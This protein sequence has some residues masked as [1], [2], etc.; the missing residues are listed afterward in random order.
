MIRI[1]SYPSK[2]L[3][4]IE[5]KA[6]RVCDEINNNNRNQENRTWLC[7]G[8]PGGKIIV[9]EKIWWRKSYCGEKI[10]WRN[11]CAGGKI[12]WWKNILVKIPGDKWPSEK[13]CPGRN[14]S[15][16]ANLPSHFCRMLTENLLWFTSYLLSLRC[17]LGTSSC[18]TLALV[19]FWCFMEILKNLSWVLVFFYVLIIPKYS[20]ENIDM[21]F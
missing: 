15:I 3:C 21:F 6:R 17:L 20:S 4:Q 13:K 9:V 10:S 5:Y 11:K 2:V 19:A 12:L 18:A 14:I 8:S 16:E 7:P 1:S